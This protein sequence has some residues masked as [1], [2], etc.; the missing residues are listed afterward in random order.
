[1][2]KAEFIGKFQASF[3]GTPEQ[4]AKVFGK[5]DKDGDGTISMS[6]IGNLFKSMDGDGQC[7]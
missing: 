3:G 5:L 4:G 1:M 2:S 6:E 7:F